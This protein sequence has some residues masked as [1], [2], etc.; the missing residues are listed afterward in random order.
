M[1]S[2]T[3]E[4]ELGDNNASDCDPGCLQTLEWTPLEED[5][6]EYKYYR[7]GVGMVQEADPDDPE[8]TAELVEFSGGME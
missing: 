7:M 8:N 1:I 3:A 4:P 6:Y 5:S 2:L